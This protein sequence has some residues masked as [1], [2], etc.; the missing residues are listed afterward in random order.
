[1]MR[2]SGFRERLSSEGGQVWVYIL[3]I[4]LVALVIGLL[5]SQFG[6]IIA[7]HI[8]THSTASDAASEAAHIYNTSRSM[9]KVTDAVV[10]F[11]TDRGARLDGAIN[12][13]YDESGR[14]AKISVPVRKVV[15]TFL[16][17]HVGYLAPY[18]EAH[19]VGEGELL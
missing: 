6:P 18:T 16:F 19:A 7:N 13:V 8:S 11:L 4:F 3:K 10:K 15:N 12:I 2:R 5:I 17:E 14:P 1:M 9:E